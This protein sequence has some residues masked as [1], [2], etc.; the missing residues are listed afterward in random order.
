VLHAG[1]SAGTFPAKA[2]TPEHV[3]LLMTG[4]AGEATHRA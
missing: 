4:A 3:G 2:T 1:R